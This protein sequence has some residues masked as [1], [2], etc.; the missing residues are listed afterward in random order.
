MRSRYGFDYDKEMKEL[1]RRR[2]V[3]ETFEIIKGEAT[4]NADSCGLLVRV[5]IHP[6]Y[7]DDAT[8]EVKCSIVRALMKSINKAIGTTKWER[9]LREHSGEGM[10]SVYR[11]EFFNDPE[12][13]EYSNR[14]L[15]MIEEAPTP[16]NCKLIKKTKKVTY[17]EMDCKDSPTD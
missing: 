17:Y 1:N 8:N 14:L 11:E 5:F 3:N 16:P 10:W 12:A 7:P 15:V 9:N 4:F 13:S 6:I 2:F